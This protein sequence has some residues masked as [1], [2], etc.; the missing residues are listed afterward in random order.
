[1]REE[2]DKPL[3]KNMYIEG[4]SLNAASHDS[5]MLWINIITILSFVI[6]NTILVYF[7]IRYRRRGDNDVTSR[8]DHSPTLEVI[9]TTI[10]TIVM[11]WL[12]VWGL[13]EFVKLRTIPENARE[14]NVSAK[15]WLGVLLIPAI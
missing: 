13:V 5:L 11:V 3:A 14:I 9:W 4:A 8:I 10:P 2:E 7:I 1:M 12:Y 6:V 15:Q